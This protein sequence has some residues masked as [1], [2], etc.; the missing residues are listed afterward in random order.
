MTTKKRIFISAGEPSGDIHAAGLLKELLLLSPN[1]RISGLGGDELEKLG[2]RLLYHCR[3]LAAIGFWEVAK[4]IGHYIKVKNDCA[5]FMKEQ[6]PDLTILVDYPGMNLKLARISHNL[7]IPTA[8]FILPQVWA[9]NSKRTFGLKKYCHQLISILPFEVDFFNKFGV[10]IDYIGHPLIDIIPKETNRTALRQRLGFEQDRKIIAFLPG[11][12]GQE[13]QRN[14]PP[15]RDAFRLLQNQYGNITGI[16]IKA[17]ALGVE[18]Y[19]DILKDRS[20]SFE[21]INENRYDYI[22]ACDAAVVASGTATLETALCGAPA[23]V[24]YRTSML[25]YFIA[26]RVVQIDTIALA[27]LVA[28]EIIYPELVQKKATAEN[29]FMELKRI[30]DD[31]RHA[32]DVRRRLT[33][34][35]ESLKPYGAYARGAKLIYERYLNGTKG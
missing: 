2:A 9:W 21:I 24:V 12:R 34:I 8:Y 32:D 4:K 19:K 16:I 33:G 25:T 23:V 11:S 28:K 29:I 22:K 26:K 10:Q 3:D 1:I 18:Q 15:M 30:I 6:K 14:L 27:N 31:N 13:L 5:R 7:D 35:R 17:P 20:D